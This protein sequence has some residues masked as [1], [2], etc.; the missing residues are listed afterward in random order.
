MDYHVWESVKRS[1]HMHRP[2]VKIIVG[3]ATGLR[4]TDKAIKV[5]TY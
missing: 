5:Y 2:K 4:T 1:N 3:N